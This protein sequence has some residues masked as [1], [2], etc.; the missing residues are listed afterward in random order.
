MNR[1]GVTLSIEAK[2]VLFT[3]VLLPA[4]FLQLNLLSLSSILSFVLLLQITQQ[5]WFVSNSIIKLYSH[6]YTNPFF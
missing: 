2:I 3:Q 1:L 6:Y 5:V 4:P